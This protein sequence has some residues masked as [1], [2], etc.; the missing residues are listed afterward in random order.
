MNYWLHFQ[1]WKALFFLIKKIYKHYN[2]V[3]TK[4]G[5]VIFVS[6]D[7]CSHSSPIVCLTDIRLALMN[8]ILWQ[9]TWTTVSSE[10]VIK[11][12][13]NRKKQTHSD[14][15]WCKGNGN[16]KPCGLLSFGPCVVSSCNSLQAP[17]DLSALLILIYHSHMIILQIPDYTTVFVSLPK[18]IQSYFIEINWNKY[19]LFCI[20][21]F[22]NAV[23]C[24]QDRNR[25]SK[26]SQ[27]ISPQ[28]C[29]DCSM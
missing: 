26:Y 19:Q 9:I 11:K 12:R 1:F 16:K 18:T 5:S 10:H 13:T 27:N 3:I 8:L 6:F 14:L 17:P 22:E 4:N 20:Y 24:T 21:H 28:H 7:S 25:M 15:H 2:H 23:M 29:M